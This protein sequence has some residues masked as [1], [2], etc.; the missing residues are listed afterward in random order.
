MRCVPRHRRTKGSWAMTHNL[1]SATPEA[2]AGYAGGL[3]EHAALF[4]RIADDAGYDPALAGRLR[5]AAFRV[6]SAAFV[7]RSGDERR[8]L[9]QDRIV[10]SIERALREEFGRSCPIDD[11][12]SREASEKV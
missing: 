10:V 9:V 11:D 3:A 4:Q 7:L 2:I 5:D 12:A 1:P 6:Q 8:R